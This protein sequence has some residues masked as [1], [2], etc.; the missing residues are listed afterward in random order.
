MIKYYLFFNIK[1]SHLLQL[2]RLQLQLSRVAERVG[3][4]PP[5]QQLL[6][7]LEV[8]ARRVVDEGEL[9]QRSEHEGQA[10]ARPHVYGLGEKRYI[11]NK[12]INN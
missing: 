8:G 7:A 6:V 3:L 5:P 4:E 12:E 9:K 10:H 2:L 1:F 11:F